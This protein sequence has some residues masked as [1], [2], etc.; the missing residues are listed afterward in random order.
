LASRF[1]LSA[2]SSQ[3]KA[4]SM[5]S[6]SIVISRIPV[7]SRGCGGPAPRARPDT[8]HRIYGRSNKRSS[9]GHPE[10]SACPCAGFSGAAGMTVA[11]SKGIRLLGMTLS[12]LGEKHQEGEPQL[13]LSF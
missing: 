5:L 3:A 1:S 9:E 7:L 8:L 10:F 2:L 11:G 12:S 13:S 4:A 6:G